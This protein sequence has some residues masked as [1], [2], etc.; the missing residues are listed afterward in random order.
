MGQPSPQPPVLAASTSAPVT[1]AQQFASRQRHRKT[2]VIATAVALFALAV[3]PAVWAMFTRDWRV[4]LFWMVP[5]GLGILLLKGLLRYSKGTPHCPN[6]QQ[7]VTDC[8]AVFCHLCGATL[9]T[10][11]CDHCGADPTWTAGF[12]DIGLRQ[13]ITFCPG[14][15]VY[16]S[17]PFYRFEDQPD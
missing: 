4:A 10:R 15:G 1:Y 9:K 2:W 14:C 16:L 17:T 13:H 6:C 7:N 11:V 12:Q 5:A 3:V 8:P